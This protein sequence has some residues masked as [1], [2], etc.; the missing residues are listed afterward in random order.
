MIEN[1]KTKEQKV[2]DKTLI[3]KSNAIFFMKNLTKQTLKIYWQH[4]LNYKISGLF[5]IVYIISASIINVIV[6]LYLKDFFNALVSNNAKD[7]ILKNLIFILIIIASLKLLHWLLWR[8]SSFI[9]ADFQSKI[10][11]D[12][13]NYCFAYLHKHCFTFF[14]NN[15]VGSLVKQINGFVKAFEGISE[16]IFYNIIPLIITFIAI[17]IVL[18]KE[19]IFLGLG[20]IIWLI[21]FLIINWFFT[22]YKFQYDINA[23]K[24][25]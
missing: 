15:F 3:Q 25:K 23:I 10:M 16:H 24:L 5:I 6:P 11:V 7:I 22:K 17:T 12:L 18:F 13:S 1:D 4:I 20:I 21:I 19:N 9:N 14:E 8:I 2:D